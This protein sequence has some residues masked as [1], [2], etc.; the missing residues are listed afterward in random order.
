MFDEGLVSSLFRRRKSEKS[1]E[2]N[3]CPY[4]EFVNEENVETCVQCYYSMNLAAR[5]Q[6][7]ATPTTTGSELMNTLME[8]NELEKEEFAV[9]AVLSLDEVAVEVDQYDLSNDKEDSFQFIR[10]STPELSQTVEFKQQQEVELQASDAPKNPVVFDMGDENPLDEVQEPVH[11][12]LGNLYSP[13]VK[14]ETDDDLMGSVGPI[15]EGKTA[16]P[17]LPTFSNLTQ[18]VQQ[19]TQ[20]QV[21]TP[22]QMTTPDIPDVSTPTQSIETPATAQNTQLPA[23]DAASAIVTPEIPTTS[24]LS[25]AADAESKAISEDIDKTA[26]QTPAPVPQI[27][28]RFWPWPA[29]TPWD[30]RQVY[31]EVV[32][33]LESI[34]SGQLAKAAETLDALGP[35]LEYN[36]DM[37]L[38]IGSAMRALN[39]EEHL[40]WTLS[41]AKHVHPN[42]EHVMAAVAQLS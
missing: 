37:L 33:I 35:H 14:S 8:E 2:G 16:T 6:P 40:Q 30:A 27:P 1:V 5:N 36:F 38:H 34:K 19:L 7:M 22:K 12:G 4:C 25:T 17:D 23:S 9:E 26:V 20:P 15:N 32:Q 13:S 42:N 11:T 10:G 29:R 39:R 28:S 18:P 21:E 3:V 31:R 41:M 24:Q